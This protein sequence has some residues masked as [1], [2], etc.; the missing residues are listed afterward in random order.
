MKIRP[1]ADKVLVERV[2]AARWAIGGFDGLQ[3]KP[4]TL[5]FAQYI[6]QRVMC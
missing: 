3:L 4:E 2:E 5:V 1:L 6:P